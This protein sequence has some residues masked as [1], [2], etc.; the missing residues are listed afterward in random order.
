MASGSQGFVLPPS[1]SQETYDTRRPED[2][3][4]VIVD[5]FA[6]G[7]FAGNPAAVVLYDRYPASAECVRLAQRFRQPVTVF[8]RPLKDAGH[9]EIR[10]FTQNA[11]LD[12][13]G[14]GTLAATYWACS[15]AGYNRNLHVSYQSRSGVL[16]GWL[17]RDVVQVALPAIETTAATSTEYEA[18]ER[19][20]GLPV[21]EIRKA[22]D[23]FVVVV[24]DE[25]AVLDYDP[26]FRSI[27]EIDCRGIVLTALVERNGP[28][29]EFD[30]VSR[31]F[32]P[33]IAIDEDQVCVSAHCK[34]YPYWAR[35]LGKTNLRALQ[36]SESGGVLQLSSSDGHV[37]VGG[38]AQLANVERCHEGA[39]DMRRREP[40]AWKRLG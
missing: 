40:F 30:I 14:H 21:K 17:E 33:R 20:V 9:F 32:S 27:A 3:S 1:S 19:C 13:C 16:R 38:R 37:I 8:L 29:A 36:A 6:D 26:N 31:F 22:Y 5:A 18:V 11:E 2:A 12:L 34:L 10:W 24:G 15:S 4:P 39:R 23:D 35:V 7:R 25:R 28:L